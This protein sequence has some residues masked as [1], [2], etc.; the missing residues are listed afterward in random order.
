MRMSRYRSIT[1]R[2]I[3]RRRVYKKLSSESKLSSVSSVQTPPCQQRQASSAGGGTG[4]I[5]EA[6]DGTCARLNNGGTL[7]HLEDS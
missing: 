1:R 6:G 3:S 2:P 7:G 4:A 5:T